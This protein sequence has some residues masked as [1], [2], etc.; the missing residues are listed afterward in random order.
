MLKCEIFTFRFYL[1][2]WGYSDRKKV[3]SNHYT[4]NNNGLTMCYTSKTGTWDTTPWKVVSAKTKT[5]DKY[6]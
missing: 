6:T 4:I 5:I 3:L 1:Q 2:K